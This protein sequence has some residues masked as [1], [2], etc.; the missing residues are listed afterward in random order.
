MLYQAGVGAASPDRHLERFDDELGARMCSAIAQ[1]T[2]HQAG[3]ALAALPD[4]HSGWR[5]PSVPVCLLA[6]AAA[7][8]AAR[9]RP[10]EPDALPAATPAT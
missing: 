7:L 9:S 6:A 3:D 5:S 4:I 2:A 10:T 8:L 1:P